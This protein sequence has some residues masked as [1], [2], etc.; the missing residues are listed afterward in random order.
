MQENAGKELSYLKVLVSWYPWG[1]DSNTPCRYQI[2]GCSSPLCKMVEYSQ[3]SVSVG[4]TSMD[5]EG[6]LY[7]L[8]DKK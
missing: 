5:T 6:Q 3:P 2:W 4:S 7:N 8:I 1:T